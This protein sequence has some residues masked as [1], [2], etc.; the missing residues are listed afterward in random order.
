MKSSLAILFLIIFFLP[1]GRDVV[2]HAQTE[3]VRPLTE[4]EK[5]QAQTTIGFGFRLLQ[6]V[7]RTEE[8][9]NV[10]V[11]PF[12]V[13]TA[14]GMALNGADGMTEVAILTTLGYAGI[15]TDEINATNAKLMHSLTTIDP[16]V[17]FNIANSIWYRDGLAV[18][19]QFVDA[20]RRYYDA[21][22]RELNFRT[23]GA[24]DTINAWVNASTKGKIRTI[25]PSPI[26]RDMMMFLINAIYFKGAWTHPF[27]KRFTKDAPFYTSNGTRQVKLMLKHVKLPYT[28]NATYQAIELPYGDSLFTSIVVLPRPKES[29]EAFASGMNEKSWKTLTTELKRAD[30]TILL[31]RF[32]IEFEKSLID[33]LKAMGMG[34]AFGANA[35]FSKI[36]QTPLLISEVLH[37]TF[38]QVDEEGTE[39]TAVTSIHGQTSGLHRDEPF[40]MRVDRPF[41]FAITEKQTGALLFVGKI[42][43]PQ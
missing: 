34:I 42:V 25:A 6:E 9:R 2:A 27:E 31:P 39:A 11:S 15:P 10:F 38:L 21:A 12:S 1:F 41:L 8:G 4:A 29:I 26:P 22:V 40:V 24:S 18:N 19:P 7:N 20:N 28:E 30:G 23:S 32:K 43:D 37:K 16:K 3:G 14:L 5:R 36:S 35:N 17:Q 33:A 13:A